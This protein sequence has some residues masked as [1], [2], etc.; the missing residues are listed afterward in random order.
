MTDTKRENFRKYLEDGNVMEA[1]TH[2]LVSLYEEPEQPADPL[3]YIRQSIGAVEGV[4]ISSLIR[5]NQELKERI[6][7]LNHEIATL[8]SQLA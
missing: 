4:D 6:A 2:A 5:R 1:I 7:S 3:N 8:E